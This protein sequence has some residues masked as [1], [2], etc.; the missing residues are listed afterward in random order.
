MK[1]KKVILISL[2]AVLLVSDALADEFK[3]Y[4]MVTRDGRRLV[5]RVEGGKT[6]YELVATNA[7]PASI[8]PVRQ[9]TIYGIKSAHTDLGLHRSNYEQRKG[10]VR[11][12]EMA[13]ELFDADS[14]TDADPEAFRYVQEGW[15]DYG[16]N[17]Q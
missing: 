9:W 17:N 16:T 15:W 11:R 3:A 2:A 13:K 1:L 4:S 5:S 12:L 6:I 14:R 10:T 8:P 7:L